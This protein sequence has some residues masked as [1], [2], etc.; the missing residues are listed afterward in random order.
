MAED[1]P[2]QQKKV[3]CICRNEEHTNGRIE[4]EERSWEMVSLRGDGK[5]L[6]IVCIHRTPAESLRDFTVKACE[7]LKR[8]TNT[9]GWGSPKTTEPWE[10][11]KVSR[12]DHNS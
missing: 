10:G 8:F 6:H 5:E 7:V 4:A 3:K 2:G 9:W 1:D 11:E 12:N